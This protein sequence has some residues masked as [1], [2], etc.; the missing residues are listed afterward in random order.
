ME[1][2]FQLTFVS[3]FILT[4]LSCTKKESDSNNGP[5][6]TDKDGN[7]YNTV[8]IGGRTW[9]KEN[10]KTIHFNNGD[11]IPTLNS[12]PTDATPVYQWPA[13]GDEANVNV[14][15]RLYTWYAL[16]DSRGVCPNGWHVPSEDEWIQMEK[17]IG[18]V[19]NTTVSGQIGT[20]E[21]GKLKETG[22]AHWVSP[23]TGATNETGFTALPA[24]A[25]GSNGFGTP[26]SFGSF[27][28]S[29]TEMGGNAWTHEMNKSFSAIYHY[30]GPKTVGK[31]CRCIKD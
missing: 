19:Y 1:K 13:Y 10:L 30:G 20:T 18:L 14:Y 23:N 11:P 16:T 21:G 6:V 17:S 15:G 22:T 26:G 5:T 3:I 24:G 9:F 31:S 7:S 12:F 25:R 27:W 4:V 2:I 29:S 8:V 28:T